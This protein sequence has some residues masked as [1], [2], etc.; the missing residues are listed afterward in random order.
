MN[1]PSLPP[2]KLLDGTALVGSQSA[3]VVRAALV[4][5]M[6]A[7]LREAVANQWWVCGHAPRRELSTALVDA[8]AVGVEALD[9][10]RW[11]AMTITLA[12]HME[13]GATAWKMFLD[14]AIQHAAESLVDMAEEGA[15]IT[16]GPLQ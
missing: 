13:T 11:A 3:E 8:F 2:I 14:A 5:D 10:K 9:F 6:A 15:V 7:D 16:F 4:A 12:G 1:L